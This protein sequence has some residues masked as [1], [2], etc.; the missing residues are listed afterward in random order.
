MPPLAAA[1]KRVPG[2][3]PPGG[4]TK[5][6]SEVDE[7]ARRSATADP[8]TTPPSTARIVRGSTMA[9]LMREEAFPAG[10]CGDTAT[11]PWYRP[12]LGQQDS[13]YHH[14]FKKT[15]AWSPRDHVETRRPL[16]GIGRTLANKIVGTT[17]PLR[18]P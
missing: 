18:R 9:P 17:M 12:H 15:I 3:A 7:G 11:T 6:V 2:S 14:A 16:R 10:S 5:V 13:W 8:S 1:L 4:M